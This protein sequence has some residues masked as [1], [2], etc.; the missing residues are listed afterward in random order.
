[1]N[2]TVWAIRKVR[3]GGRVK[4]GGQ[5]FR[6]SETYA[7]YDGRLDGLTYA[8]GRYFTGSI[9]GRREYMPYVNCWG[10]AESF[11]CDAPNTYANDPQ[12]ME[13][14]GLPWMFW[15]AEPQGT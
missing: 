7:P 4:I 8:F 13:D 6:P 3:T 14:G 9:S 5:W 1:M 11:N 15:N 12:V 2:E 10:L